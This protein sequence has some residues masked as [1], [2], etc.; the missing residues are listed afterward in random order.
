MDAVIRRIR[1]GI[2]LGAD[3]AGVTGEGAG[4]AATAL[5]GCRDPRKRVHEP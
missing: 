2:H 3:E 1:L 4:Y 5:N